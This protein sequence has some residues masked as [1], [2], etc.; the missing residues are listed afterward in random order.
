M[1]QLIE[2]LIDHLTEK[3]LKEFEKINGFIKDDNKE[4][5]LITSG[6]LIE[7]DAIIQHLNDMLKFYSQLQ[8]VEQ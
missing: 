5:I 8:H 7:L 3:R 1:E 6:R 4:I 2:N